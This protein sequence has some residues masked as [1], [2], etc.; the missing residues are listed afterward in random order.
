MIY[1]LITKDLTYTK[2]IGSGNGRQNI[3]IIFKIVKFH[4]LLSDV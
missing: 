2:D 3:N 4:G 1:T